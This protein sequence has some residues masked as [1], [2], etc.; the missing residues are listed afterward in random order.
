MY[1][2]EPVYPLPLAIGLG[3]LY[4]NESGTIMLRDREGIL[5]PMTIAA[6]D[7]YFKCMNIYDIGTRYG[8]P[9]KYSM[10]GITEMIWYCQETHVFGSL[11]VIIDLFKHRIRLGGSLTSIHFLH[12]LVKRTYCEDTQLGADFTSGRY[13]IGTKRTRSEIEEL[14][15]DDLLKFAKSDP[16]KMSV[17][18]S[19]RDMQD[20]I[21]V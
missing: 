7:Y 18:C 8:T 15:K 17:V 9:V 5:R 16:A 21:E 14:I 2:S 19:D 10:D 13:V 4:I 6:F 12:Y 11:D 20:C 1:Y 3:L